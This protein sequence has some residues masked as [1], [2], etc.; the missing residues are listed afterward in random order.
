MHSDI[1][2]RELDAGNRMEY[3]PPYRW[4]RTDPQ[5]ESFPSGLDAGTEGVIKESSYLFLECFMITSTSLPLYLSTLWVCP[6]VGKDTSSTGVIKK[7]VLSI[8]RVLHEHLNQFA[9][10]ICQLYG[11]VKRIH[12]LLP[13][14]SPIALPRP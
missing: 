8:F 11:C 3:I 7:R 9:P 14:L 2:A 4:A 5:P 13:S 12:L 6:S 1:S 10:Y